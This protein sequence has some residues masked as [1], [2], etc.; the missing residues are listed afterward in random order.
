MDTNKAIA[1]LELEDSKLCNHST[2][3][4]CENCFEQFELDFE[5]LGEYNEE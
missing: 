1:M 2:D 5:D 3:E 4:Y